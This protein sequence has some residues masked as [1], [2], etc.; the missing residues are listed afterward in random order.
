MNHEFIY[1][2]S[3]PSTFL[4]GIVVH[5]VFLRWFTVGSLLVHCWFT[6]GSLWFLRHFA[7]AERDCA[8]GAPGWQEAPCAQG[9]SGKLGAQMCRARQV[10]QVCQVRQVRLWCDASA[11]RAR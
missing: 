4:I 11:T 10:C 5:Y 1:K 6:V 3:F 8:P 9:A 7:D 2:G